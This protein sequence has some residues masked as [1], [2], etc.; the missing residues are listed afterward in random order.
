M[1]TDQWDPSQ[2][3][4]LRMQL[5][6]GTKAWSKP[7]ARWRAERHLASASWLAL[8]TWKGRRVVSAAI[9]VWAGS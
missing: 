7:M 9:V 4:R 3:V 6:D 5:A 2:T 1:S 8:P